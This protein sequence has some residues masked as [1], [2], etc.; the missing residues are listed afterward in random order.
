MYLRYRFYYL[1]SAVILIIAMG[2]AVTYPMGVIGVILA[3][4]ILRYAL[5]INLNKEEHTALRG[6]GSTE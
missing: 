5:R 3:F 6:L 4:L 1:L 2:Y